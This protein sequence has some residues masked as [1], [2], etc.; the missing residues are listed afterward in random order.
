MVSSVSPPEVWGRPFKAA[1]GLPPGITPA[2]KPD[3]TF[4]PAILVTMLELD[5][6]VLRAAWTVFVFVL[7]IALIYLT[8]SVLVIFTLAIFLAH[9]IAPLVDRVD[10][11]TPRRVCRTRSSRLCTSH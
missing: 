6:R 1:A 9:L 2:G 7:V 5:G 10:R 4:Q 8:R 3:P 11:L